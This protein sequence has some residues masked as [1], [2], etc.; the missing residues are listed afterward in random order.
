MACCCLLVVVVT[1]GW[2][3]LFSDAL[4]LLFDPSCMAGE[5]WTL[6]P[7]YN[8][9]VLWLGMVWPMQIDGVWDRDGLLY[10]PYLAKL[11]CRRECYVL[12]RHIR[13]DVT[14]LL[15]ECNRGLLFLH[16]GLL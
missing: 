8:A 6:V 15:E 14:D 10:N 13:P 12:C 3:L 7:R 1:S 5:S 2:L 9:F 16:G 4:L 11:L